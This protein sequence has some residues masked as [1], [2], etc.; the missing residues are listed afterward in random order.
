[1]SVE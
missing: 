1:L